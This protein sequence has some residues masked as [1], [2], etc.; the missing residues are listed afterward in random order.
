MAIAN[1]LIQARGNN[2]R[3]A[4]MLINM[5]GETSFVIGTTL[6]VTVNTYL[7]DN[8]TKVDN[9]EVILVTTAAVTTPVEIIGLLVDEL[10]ENLTSATAHWTQNNPDE[11]VV[12]V[13]STPGSSW[14]AV[15]STP[16]FDNTPT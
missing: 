5:D 3:S 2:D 9:A 6:G 16:V 12:H 7:A 8:S 15:L 10:N 1:T 13:E 11:F 4:M 14:Y